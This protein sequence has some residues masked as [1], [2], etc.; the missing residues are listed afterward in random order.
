MSKIDAYLKNI[1]KLNADGKGGNWAGIGQGSVNWPEVRRALDEVGY[2]GWLTD[3]TGLT[4]YNQETARRKMRK[5]GVLEE[6]DSGREKLFINPGLLTLLTS[7][8]G[9]LRS[10]VEQV[11]QGE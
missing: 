3:E 8:T 11:R 6:R 1:A 10:V 4:R 9:V 5:T 7:R 2:N